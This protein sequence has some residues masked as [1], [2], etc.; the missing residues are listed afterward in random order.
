MHR[1]LLPCLSQYLVPTPSTFAFSKAPNII[2][3]GRS[4]ESKNL[5]GTVVMFVPFPIPHSLE[6]PP[7]QRVQ[8][9][10]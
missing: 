6:N 10:G 5:E 8:H 7:Q 2:Q 1:P 9:P 3:Q 4:I